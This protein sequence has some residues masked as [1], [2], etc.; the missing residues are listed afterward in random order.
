MKSV[1][2][3]GQGEL[4]DLNYVPSHIEPAAVRMLVKPGLLVIY[5]FFLG[6]GAGFVSMSVCVCVCV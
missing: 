5:T 3:R 1:K 2:S 6:R 4:C